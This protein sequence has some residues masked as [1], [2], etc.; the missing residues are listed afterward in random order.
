LLNLSHL[1]R[2]T[3]DTGL[4]QHANFTVPNYHEGYATDD[5]A[6]GL[7]VAVYLE[8]RGEELPEEMAVLA[9]RY[10]A[11]LIHAFNSLN[12][13]FRNFLSFDR[14]WHEKAGS[15]DSHGRALWGLGTVIGRSKQSGLRGAAAQLFESALPVTEEFASPRAWAFTLLAIHEYLKRF[16]GD[17]VARR[18]GDVLSE[19]LLSLYRRNYSADWPWF[20]YSL[21]YCNAV[22]PHALLVSGQ[23]TG[24]QEL[25]E[26]ALHSLE[27]LGEIQQAAQGHFVPIGC[28]GFYPRGGERAR[29]DQQ[30]VEAQA[31]ISA[32]L[33]AKTITGAGFWDA[34]LHRTFDWF[35]G[36][37]D[38]GLSL[39]DPASGGCRDGLHSD[40]CNQNQGAESTLAFLHALLEIRLA[41][42]SAAAETP[43]TVTGTK[44]QESG[45]KDQKPGAEKTEAIAANRH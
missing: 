19:R 42:A 16:A 10:L 36:R 15:E 7:I 25:I 8:E 35:L 30:P 37:N 22:L 9:F 40:R 29:F 24:R 20:E 34:H 26:A 28:K 39:Y 6:R 45:V 1:R 18:L 44:D 21:T 43:E 12:S 3:D 31:M 23:A 17:R 33:A 5:N 41:E 11:F 27:W 4:V 14:H 38:L 2:L 32:C 13:R